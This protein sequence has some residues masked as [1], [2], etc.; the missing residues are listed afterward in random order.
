MF[1]L[2]ILGE[3]IGRLFEESKH[4]PVYLTRKLINLDTPRQNS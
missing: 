3:Y 2:G 1:C 4:R